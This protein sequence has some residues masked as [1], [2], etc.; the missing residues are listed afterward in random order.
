MNEERDPLTLG[1][2]LSLANE[3]NA[4]LEKLRSYETCVVMFVDLVGSTQFKSLNPNEE[5][6]LPRLCAFLEA[7]S[8]LIR[9]EGKVV[10]F[11][12]DEVMALFTGSRA[13]QNAEHVAENILLFCDTYQQYNFRVKIGL[14]FGKVALLKFGGA[15][16]GFS[17]D[18]DPQGVVVDRCARIISKAGPGDVLCSEYF[19]GASNVRSK[20]R[21]CGSFQ[22]KGIEKKVNVFELQHKNSRRVKIADG[23]MDLGAC[24]KRIRELEAVI[25]GLKDIQR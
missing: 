13:V 17:I 5:I 15:A 10:K 4:R 24:V 16:E 25:E 1:Q 23:E 7:I 2:V 22:A 6:W 11:I 9:Q 20:W 8:G 12:G 21:R 18:G 19:Y 3:I 14:D